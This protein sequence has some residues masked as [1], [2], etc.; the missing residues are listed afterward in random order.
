MDTTFKK[1]NLRNRVLELRYE[2]DT[3]CIYGNAEGLRR[4]AKLCEQLADQPSEGHI[5]LENCCLLTDASESG[6][7]A[8]FE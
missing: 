7:L 1:P 3:V 2:N 4:L 6:A 5:H 8:V